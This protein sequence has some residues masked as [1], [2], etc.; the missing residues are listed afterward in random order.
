[1]K[2]APLLRAWLHRLRHPAQGEP[3]RFHMRHR[4]NGNITRTDTSNT[5]TWQFEFD[6]P[7]GVQSVHAHAVLLAL[8]GGS[9]ARLG[10]D[11]AWQSWLRALQTGCAHASNTHLLLLP[12]TDLAE[13]K[14]R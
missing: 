2:A 5:P 14:A 4:W 7:H 11:G 6:T 3:V 9:W 10:S 13:S 12:Q 1:M 8:G